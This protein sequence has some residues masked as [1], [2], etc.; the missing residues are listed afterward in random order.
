M[1]ISQIFKPQIQSLL[2]EESS[3][4]PKKSAVKIN[5]YLINQTILMPASLQHCK[6][7]INAT[8]NMKYNK[9]DNTLN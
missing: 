4:S 7:I 2:L 6:E 9:R 5:K 1:K 3:M 8:I